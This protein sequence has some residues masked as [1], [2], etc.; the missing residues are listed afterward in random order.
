MLAH[1]WNP[2]SVTWFQWAVNNTTYFKLK[3]ALVGGHRGMSGYWNEYGIYLLSFLHGVIFLVRPWHV[4]MPNFPGYTSIN[5]NKTKDT[6]CSVYYHKLF[7]DTL[8][9]RKFSF[10]EVEEFF[11]VLKIKKGPLLIS[12]KISPSTEIGTSYRHFAS[13][14]DEICILS[15]FNLT[16][17]PNN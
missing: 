1:Y 7:F 16:W 15:S 10:Y 8:P 6:L 13:I 11:F 3:I 5:H 2:L 14:C 4:S 12:I 17:Y 9:V